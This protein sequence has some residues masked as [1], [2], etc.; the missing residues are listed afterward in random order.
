M[1]T[2]TKAY[3]VAYLREVD[4]GEAI[5]EYLR[6]IDLTLAPYGGRFLVHGGDIDAVE[7]EWDG[8]V[9]VL[10]FP[11]RISARE[12]Y[13]SPGYQEILP[14]RTEHSQSIVAIVDGVEPGHSAVG[15]LSSLL[16]AE[17]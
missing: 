4:F 5:I 8:D 1:T 9:V 3:A 13:D 12:W 7:G 10:E 16:A 6:R 2:T 17:S 11:D 15:K 14:L